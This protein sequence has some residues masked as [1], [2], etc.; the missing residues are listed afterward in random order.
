VISLAWGY[1]AYTC[2]PQGILNS[3]DIFQNRMRGLF[4][5]MDK[6][7]KCYIDEIIII[8][9][10]TYEEHFLDVVAVFKHLYKKDMQVHCE[11]AKCKKKKLNT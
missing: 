4:S 9:R 8:G 10:G 2:L 1:Y 5:N 7:V 6:I 11:K 3:S